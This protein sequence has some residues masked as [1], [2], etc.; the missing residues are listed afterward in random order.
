GGVTQPVLT[1]ELGGK[2]QLLGSTIVDA[3][4]GTLLARAAFVTGLYHNLLNRAPDDAGMGVWVRQL[5][6]GMSRLDVAAAFWRSPEHRTIEVD[7]FYNTFL[8]RSADAGGRAAW[9]NA[10]LNGSTERD[11]L[12][13]ILAS[14][15]YA[16][17]AGSDSA[18][19]VAQL[20]VDV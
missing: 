1:A 9:V 18:T 10:L 13:A 7:Y 2:F 15:E 6:M 5:E 14:D 12:G 11:I 20:Y 4:S 19:Y 16:A 3:A 17:R 8:R